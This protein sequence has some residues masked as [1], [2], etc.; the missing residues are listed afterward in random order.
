MSS[1]PP[2]RILPR[3]DDHNREFWTGGAAGE[4]RFWRCQDCGYY[5]HPPQPICPI[6]HSK[7]LAV[8]AVSGRGDAHDVLGQLP[9]L[10][11]GAGAA[12]R[13]CDRRDRRAT[14]GTAHDESRELPARRHRDRHAAARHVRAPRRSRRRRVHPVV[15]AWDPRTP[16]RW[17]DE[18]TGSSSNESSTRVH[19]R[20][21]P[22]GDRPPAVPR[23]AGADARRLPR[24]DRRR[25][26]RRRPTST[27]CRPI[28]V[29]WA[30]P[31]GSAARARTT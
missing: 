2:F 31:P 20:R 30:S 15:R 27:A 3:L 7:N 16:P 26:A 13:R 17:H 24:R 22:V 9:E 18:A 25:R 10:D 5:I 6:D 4:L 23:S 21:R 29:R 1:D 11:A 12:V 14:V 19:H 8:E 28:P